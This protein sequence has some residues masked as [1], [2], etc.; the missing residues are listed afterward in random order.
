MAHQPQMDARLARR[1]QQKKRQLDG[2]R[3]LERFT[4]QRLHQDLRLLA[5]YHS[6]A[7]EGNT[8][9]LH[10]TQMVLEYGI[11]VDGHPLREYLEATNHAEAFDKLPV[12]IER[13]I[14]IETVQHLHA[15]VMDKIDPQAGE[16]RK[17]QVY[18]RGA[19][20]TP[21]AARDVALYLAQWINWLTSDIALH[22]D[23]VIRAAIA[24]HDFEALHP[25]TDGN[26]RVGRLLLNLMLMQDG[27]PPALVL[28]EW[29]PRYIQALQQAYAGEYTPLVNLVGQAVEQS[30]D[31]YLE[32]CVESTAHLLPLNELA[33]LFNTTVDYLGQLAR[34]GKLEARKQGQHWYASKEAVQ[35]YFQEANTQPRG[36][37]RKKAIT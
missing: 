37:P 23:P 12:L 28:R 9:S 7:I 27:Y 8:L 21:P 16:L 26:G 14:T 25:F 18:I 19:P 33:P 4:V 10:E 32:A 6:N 5:T 20:F 11:T 36:R 17:V 13:P 1:L 24:H 22:Y 31:L 15:L 34:S 35:Q 2:Y 29:R 30:L 3:P